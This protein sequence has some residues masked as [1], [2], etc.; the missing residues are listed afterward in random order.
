MEEYYSEH[1]ISRSK[2]LCIGAVTKKQADQTHDDAQFC[3]GFGYYLFMADS[4]KPAGGIQVIAKLASE[5]AAQQLS[6][7]LSVTYK[8]A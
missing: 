2:V 8:L 1:T 5:A 6:K 4:D 3:D 7:L